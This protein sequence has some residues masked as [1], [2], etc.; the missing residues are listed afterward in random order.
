MSLK[1]KVNDSH[2]CFV[3]WMK[4]RLTCSTMESGY[5]N[6]TEKNKFSQKKKLA[7]AANSDMKHF[8]FC[9]G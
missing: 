4:Y 5:F 7:I 6:Y 8:L 2:L 9:V 1:W 3:F